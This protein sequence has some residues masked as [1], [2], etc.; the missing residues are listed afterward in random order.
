MKN[1]DLHTHSIYSDGEL[2]PKE[3]VKRAK[4]KGI[5]Y[6][7]LTDHNSV[8][9]IEEAIKEGEK[10]GIIII[11]SVELMVKENEVLGYFIDYKNINLKKDLKRASYYENEKTK[12]RINEL[13]KKGFDISYEKFVNYF[14]YSKD[15]HNKGHLIYYFSKIQGH[16]RKD[17][18]NILDGLKIKKPIKKNLSVTKGIELIKKYSG[19]PVLAHPWINKKKFTEKNVKKWVKAGLRGIEIENG[20]EFNFGR[21]KEFV[22]KIKNMAKKYNLIITS[23]S[24]Y[25]GETM[26]KFTGTHKLG[27]YNCDEKIV[28]QLE[29][30]KIY[31]DKKNN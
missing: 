8:E 2:T 25:H 5:K 11:P 28:K 24:D 12:R 6:L 19:I 14:S 16:S 17:I 29:E 31:N 15:N 18:L 20:E 23:G 21:T 9:G 1:A 22:K 13:K 7:A 4:R 27:N 10:L 26:I 3:I 30:L